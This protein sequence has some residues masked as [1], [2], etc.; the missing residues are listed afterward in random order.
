MSVSETEAHVSRLTGRGKDQPI[1]DYIRDSSFGPRFTTGP[2][3]VISGGKYSYWSGP[4]AG[5]MVG[6]EQ[7]IHSRASIVADWNSGY[8]FG[9]DGDRDNRFVFVS[10]GVTL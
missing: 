5:A 6:Y 10:Y 8:S 9:N 3:G 1:S 2:Y 4:K 7:P